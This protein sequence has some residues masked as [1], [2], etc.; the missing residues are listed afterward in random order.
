MFILKFT[1][2]HIYLDGMDVADKSWWRKQVINLDE[3]NGKVVNGIL[4]KIWMDIG[5]YQEMYSL[6]VSELEYQL[7]VR[8][9]LQCRFNDV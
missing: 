7:N 8:M 4:D 5:D 6:I 2:G 9:G 3:E 1:V